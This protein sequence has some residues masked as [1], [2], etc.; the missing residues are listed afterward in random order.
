MSYQSQIC[1]KEESIERLNCKNNYK[2]KHN[3]ML[4]QKENW[5]NKIRILEV[6][7]FISIHHDKR[8]QLKHKNNLSI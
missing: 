3:T 2:N 1:K 8:K 4:R 5:L 6:I 7:D